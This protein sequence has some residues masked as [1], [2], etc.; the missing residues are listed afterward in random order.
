MGHIIEANGT[1]DLVISPALLKETLGEAPP[2][3][4]YRVESGGATLIVQ[5]EQ[6]E[7][8]EKPITFDEWEQGWKQL[9]ER[10]SEVW[11]TDKSAA[12]IIS[13]MRR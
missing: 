9:Q 13:E 12:E 3:A 8:S 1:G 10:M 4:R 2:R 11:N 6:T 7:P 5:P